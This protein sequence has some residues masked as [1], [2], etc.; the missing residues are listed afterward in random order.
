MNI[1]L[2]DDDKA[3]SEALTRYL[4]GQSYQV[5]TAPTL[6]EGRAVLKQDWPELIVLDLGLPD[7]DGIGFVTEMRASSNVPVIIVSGR[8]EDVDRIMGIELGADDYLVKPVNPRELRARIA[9]V[10]RRAEAGQ[11]ADVGTG[12]GLLN[13]GAFTLDPERRRL[14]HAERGLVDLTSGE[15]DLL[16][17]F[18]ARP[19]RPLS[20]ETILDQTRGRS[21]R[22]FDRGVGNVFVANP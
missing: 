7:G 10:A 4:K 22:V 9:A 16:A 13:F 2:I 18:A 20:R 17:V 14:E 6:A 21:L 19:G 15:F 8:S 3:A 1:L 11:N 12:A 5:R